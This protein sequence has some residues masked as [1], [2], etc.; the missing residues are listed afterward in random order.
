MRQANKRIPESAEKTER[1]IM[2]AITACRTAVLGGHERLL[3][4]PQS[5]ARARFTNA[6]PTSRASR[7]CRRG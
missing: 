1:R 5:I 3:Q 6:S 2:G 7:R 4:K